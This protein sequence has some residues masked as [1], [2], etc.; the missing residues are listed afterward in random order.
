MRSTHPAWEPSAPR[1]KQ[2]SDCEPF[3]LIIPTEEDGAARDRAYRRGV[4]QYLFREMV[5]KRRQRPPIPSVHTCPLF[6]T[7]DRQHV[8]THRRPN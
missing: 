1:A 2:L 4:A 5:R 3:I 6:P 8:T 7:R